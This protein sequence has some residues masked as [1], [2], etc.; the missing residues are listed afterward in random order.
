[1]ADGTRSRRRATLTE[2]AAVGAAEPSSAGDETETGGVGDVTGT[3][4]PYRIPRSRRR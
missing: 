3:S 1:M 2:A 4:S